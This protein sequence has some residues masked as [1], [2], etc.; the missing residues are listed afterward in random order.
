MDY[1]MYKWSTKW[2]PQTIAKLVNIT[3]I[4]LWFMVLITIVTGAFVNQLTSLGG[5]IL[6]NF[7]LR[8][9]LVIV[10]QLHL[11]DPPTA[12][13]SPADS[14]FWR[15]NCQPFTW[16]N[17]KNHPTNISQTHRKTCKTWPEYLWFA[18]FLTRK[19]PFWGRTARTSRMWAG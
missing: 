10:A 14:W 15:L 6:Y 13:L 16:E 18:G 4:S 3:P 12:V 17:F 8:F 5:P 9:M 19:R 11:H 2:G 7:N 1:H